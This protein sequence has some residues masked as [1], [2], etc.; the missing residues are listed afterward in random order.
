MSRPSVCP[1]RSN[2][3]RKKGAERLQRLSLKGSRCRKKKKR[4]KRSGFVVC[5]LQLTIVYRSPTR[6]RSPPVAFPR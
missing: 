2:G 1:F 4:K 5:V 6:Y 3:G